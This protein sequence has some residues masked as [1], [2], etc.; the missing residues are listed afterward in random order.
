MIGKTHG[1]QQYLHPQAVLQI[2]D[3]CSAGANRLDEAAGYPAHRIDSAIRIGVVSSGFDGG[4]PGN[5]SG[6]QG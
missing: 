1:I 3:D 2:G 4:E 5:R 6:A